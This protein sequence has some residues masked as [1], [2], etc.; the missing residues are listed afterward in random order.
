MHSCVLNLL[1]IYLCILFGYADQIEQKGIG[2]VHQEC[3]QIKAGKL[4]CNS[5]FVSLLL[6]L[7]TM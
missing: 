3:C 1:V 7:R 5:L 6:D 2:I 4:S